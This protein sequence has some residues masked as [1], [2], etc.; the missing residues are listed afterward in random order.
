MVGFVRDPSNEFT[1][2]PVTPRQPISPG[3]LSYLKG[4]KGDPGTPGIPGAP[5]AAGAPGTPGIAGT[6]GATGAP[7][8]SGA[9]SRVYEHTQISAAATWTI[10]HALGRFPSAVRV[11]VGSQEVLADVEDA[12]VNTTVV[13]HGQ[14]TTGRVIIHE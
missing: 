2:T 13:V 10:T 8:S 7:G 6:P 1:V 11:L 4:P 12:D 14:P 9:G 3:P 5:G